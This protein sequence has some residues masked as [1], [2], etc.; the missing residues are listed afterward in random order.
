MKTRYTFIALSILA[1]AISCTKTEQ[2]ELQA[3]QGDLVTITATLPEDVE[4]KGGGL[5]TLLSWTWNS[6]DKLT[7]IGETTETV[8]IKPGFTAKKAEFEG[9]AVKGS[10]FTILY[11]GQSALESDCRGPRRAKRP[12]PTS[13]C[14]LMAGVESVWGRYATRRARSR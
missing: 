13:V 7:V 14:T 8:N 2:L 6:G 10:K 4:I 5:K 9:P 3:P 11:P 1:A 12:C